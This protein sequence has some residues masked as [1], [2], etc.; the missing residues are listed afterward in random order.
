MAECVN[1]KSWNANWARH[2]NLTAETIEITAAMTT[3]SL[4]RVARARDS[5]CG[6][7]NLFGVSSKLS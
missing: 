5:V 1:A 3:V 7:K 6:A 4:G 2:A